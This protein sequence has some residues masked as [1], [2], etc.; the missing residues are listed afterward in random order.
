MTSRLPPQPSPALHEPRLVRKF[1]SQELQ[2]LH[3]ADGVEFRKPGKGW[4]AD[5]GDHSTAA[6]NRCDA[7]ARHVREDGIGD[8]ATRAS[9]TQALWRPQAGRENSHDDRGFSGYR[10][11]PGSPVADSL[12]GAYSDCSFA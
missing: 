3:A 9:P 12:H 4:H 6:W 5:H 8:A 11:L 7:F 2:R 10:W 1:S